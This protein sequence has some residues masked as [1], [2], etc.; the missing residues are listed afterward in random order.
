MYIFILKEFF[1][2]ILF[3]S[4]RPFFFFVTKVS[5]FLRVSL[6]FDNHFL[7]SFLSNN[8]CGTC[9]V[10]HEL[11]VTTAT[12]LCRVNNQNR[13]CCQRG[14]AK[15]SAKK[16]NRCFSARNTLKRNY[17]FRNDEYKIFLKI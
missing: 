14:P 10:A 11:F 8:L 17:L 7:N 1:L 9:I 16:K 13:N 3:F 6:N 2:E 12:K 4:L 15:A 5:F